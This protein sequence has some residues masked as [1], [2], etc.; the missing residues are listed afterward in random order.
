[1]STTPSSKHLSGRPNS[2]W[3]QTGI[4]HIPN[5]GENSLH[6]APDLSNKN[7][8]T[9]REKKTSKTI[10]EAGSHYVAQG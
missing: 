2:H 8:K 1:M 10:F 9:Q 7:F 3:S 6:D 4:S 5:C